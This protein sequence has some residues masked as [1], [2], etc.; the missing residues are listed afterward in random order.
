MKSQ[1]LKGTL[2][3]NARETPE[4]A[5][6]TLDYQF[7]EIVQVFCVDVEMSKFFTYRTVL[8]SF[9]KRLE[10]FRPVEPHR[11]VFSLQFTRVSYFFKR[12]FVVLILHLHVKPE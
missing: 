5:A 9:K 4:L 7:S 11:N 12:L 3:V 1:F 2:Y 10:I 6:Q 8:L